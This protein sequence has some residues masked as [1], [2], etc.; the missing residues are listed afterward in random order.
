MKLQKYKNYMATIQALPGSQ[1]FRHVYAVNDDGQELDIMD[2]GDVSCA[3]VVSVVA[4][5]F[6][7]IDG[8]HAT[9]KSTLR[10]L[11]NSGWRETDSPKPGDIILWPAN[12]SGNEHIG[13]FLGD[14]R[15]ISNI[16]AQHVPGEHSLTMSDGREPTAFYTRDYEE[17]VVQ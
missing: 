12:S 16:S 3:Y 17:E 6:G 13:F 14:G 15:A 7:W 8:S 9:V 5:M 1:I 2:D 11:Q 4:H 10:E